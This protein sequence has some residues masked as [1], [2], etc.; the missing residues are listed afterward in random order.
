MWRLME[1]WELERIFWLYLPLLFL[2]FQL[3]RVQLCSLSSVRLSFFQETWEWWCFDSSEVFCFSS[4][5]LRILWILLVF[6][7]AQAV[8]WGIK[9]SMK[10]I[11]KFIELNKLIISLN[12]TFIPTSQAF[13]TAAFDWISSR[14]SFLD[15]RPPNDAVRL[16]LLRDCPSQTDAVPLCRVTY[17]SDN[18]LTEDGRTTSNP[19]SSMT[20]NP[21]SST[22]PSP[23]SSTTPTSGSST[24][25][26]LNYSS[27]LTST[28]APRQLLWIQCAP[29]RCDQEAR[30]KIFHLK[31]KLWINYLV[32]KFW[33]LWT[34]ATKRY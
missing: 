20:P 10:S 9:I 2:W 24:T 23:G 28:W 7:K 4:F 34:G 32:T 16:Y 14:T 25:L 12:S 33:S 22:S 30:F 3:I 11:E 21:V 26:L 6:R 1:A 17:I 31:M 8:L 29:G 5:S 27:A 18:K 19:G 13:A 15:R